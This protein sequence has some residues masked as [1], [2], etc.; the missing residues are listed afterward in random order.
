M[1]EI[2]IVMLKNN[3]LFYVIFFGKEIF[4]MVFIFLFLFVMIDRVLLF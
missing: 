2:L 4:F 1:I 3:V